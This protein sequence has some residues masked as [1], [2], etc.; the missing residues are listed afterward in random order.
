MQ[1]PYGSTRFA[2]RQRGMDVRSVGCMPG[3]S[4]TI[5]LLR[6]GHLAFLSAH[7][8][9]AG[10]PIP[11]CPCGRLAL[12]HHG[13]VPYP[14]GDHHRA[15]SVSRMGSELLAAG[16]QSRLAIWP[17]EARIALMASFIT[18]SRRDSPWQARA[19]SLSTPH[20]I[21]HRFLPNAIAGWSSSR[22]RLETARDPDRGL[23]C[24]L[25]LSDPTVPIWG[26]MLI[27]GQ[28]FLELACG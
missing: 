20:I 7:D 9:C 24:F 14:S 15:V 6:R 18:L 1:A 25:V 3:V 11:W 5:V 28:A 19:S 4:L 10:R 22:S 16:T 12:R 23:L 26:E 21:F 8:R 13:P 27:V 2:Q 17:I